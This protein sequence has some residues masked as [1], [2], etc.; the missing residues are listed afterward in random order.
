MDS[1]R[2]TEIYEAITKYTIA[3]EPDPAS[4]GPKYL[5]EIIARCRNYLNATHML[6]LEVHREKHLVQRDLTA[7]EAAYDIE[8]ADLLANDDRVRRL[9]N[10]DDRKATVSVILRDRLRAVQEL[11]GIIEDLEIVDKAIRFRHREL[12]DTMAEI[13][14]QRSLIRDELDTKSFYGDERTSDTHGGGGGSL[15]VAELEN[16]LNEAANEA[17]GK[18]S[19]RQD[20]EQ[21]L[22]DFPLNGLLCADCGKPQYDTP[23]GA[24]CGEHGGADGVEPEEAEPVV[25]ETG[26]LTDADFDAILQNV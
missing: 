16:L 10:I 12:K 5:A 8:S 2:I 17:L 3:L 4:L 6:V 19:A 21:D 11:R 7:L 13:K 15:D 23:S 18:P 26:E 14:V 25:S 1:E 22:I 24:T 20:L 9:P